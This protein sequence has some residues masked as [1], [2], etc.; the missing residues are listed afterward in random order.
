MI[1][2]TINKLKLRNVEKRKSSDR[3]SFHINAPTLD[4]LGPLHNKSI[5]STKC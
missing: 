1:L 3:L 4:K 5:E 2:I